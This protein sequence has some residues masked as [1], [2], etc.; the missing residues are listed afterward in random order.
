MTHDWAI[1]EREYARHV[2]R[3]GRR[4]AFTRLEPRATALVVVDMVPFFES[5][6]H[7]QDAIARI[8]RIAAALRVSSGTIAW[9]L[10][11]ADDPHLTDEFYGTE[12]AAMFR[13]SGGT[14][15]L[16]QRLCTALRWDAAIS[17]SRSAASARFSRGIARCT[18]CWR[19]GPS[20]P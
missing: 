3:R 17:S 15:P 14:G 13:H 6:P 11:S 9:V 12:T 5:N 2:A 10:P 19:P 18:G 4:H 16:P 7:S 1:P 20:K 8:N